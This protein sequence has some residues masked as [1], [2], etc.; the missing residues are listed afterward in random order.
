MKKLGAFETSSFFC[1]AGCGRER[2][3]GALVRVL[4]PLVHISPEILGHF[5]ALGGLPEGVGCEIGPVFETLNFRVRRWLKSECQKLGVFSHW[6]AYPRVKSRCFV[7]SL[8]IFSAQAADS[9]DAA[10]LSLG[11]RIGPRLLLRKNSR[12]FCS[13]LLL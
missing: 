5:A 1:C 3:G 10:A 6:V 2:L 11:F 4:E 13:N 8:C 12:V 7:K 9:S